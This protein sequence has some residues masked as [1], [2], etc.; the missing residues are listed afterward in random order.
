MLSNNETQQ[1]SILLTPIANQNYFQHELPSPSWH[2]RQAIRKQTRT[3]DQF[4]LWCTS[5]PHVPRNKS[6]HPLTTLSLV[7]Q[8]L[9]FGKTTWVLPPPLSVRRPTPSPKTPNQAKHLHKVTTAL[10]HL[11]LRL[12]QQSQRI[13]KSPQKDIRRALLT[14][15]KKTRWLPTTS[16][17]IKT[18]TCMSRLLALF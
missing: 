8:T 5:P 16:L 4:H 14:R 9:Q 11:P 3:P 7:R 1:N 10:Q 2:L 17:L 13:R 6:S 12:C 18:K 15:E